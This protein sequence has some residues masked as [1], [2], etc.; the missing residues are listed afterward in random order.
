MLAAVPVALSVSS[1]FSGWIADRFGARALP[2]AGMLLVAV[3][4]VALSFAGA[5]GTVASVA[6]RLALCGVGMGLFQAP[7]SALVMGALPRIGSAPAAASS[8][9]R[10][11]RAWQRRGPRGRAL[12]ARAGPGAIGETFLAGYALAPVPAR[13]SPCSPRWRRSRAARRRGQHARA[14]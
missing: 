3:G 7:N 5:D 1:P 9:R 2:A 10:A 14:G 13:P 4:L 8:R 6:A 12:R 11:T